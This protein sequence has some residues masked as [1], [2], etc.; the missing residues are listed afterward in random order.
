MNATLLHK[1]NPKRSKLTMPFRVIFPIGTLMVFLILTSCGTHKAG[2]TVNNSNTTQKSNVDKIRF[3]D[4]FFA[5]QTEKMKKENKKAISYFK[6]AL[7]IDNNNATCYYEIA[8]LYFSD[9]KLPDAEKHAQRAVY[10]E[11]HNKWFRLLLGD[12]YQYEKKWP[13][14][15]ENNEALISQYPDEKDYYTNLA[16]VYINQ[17]KANEAIKTYDRIEK[18]FGVENETLLQKYKIYYATQKYEKAAEQLN[19]IINR[20]PEN[21][22]YYLSLLAQCYIKSGNDTKALEL[23]SELEKNAPED[24]KIQMLIAEYYIGK[25]D[26]PKYMAAIKK[27]FASPALDIDS[28]VRI[29]YGSYLMANMDSTRLSDAA[30]LCEIIAQ[31]H[32]NDAKSHALYADILNEQNAY[33]QARIE[34]LKAI[35]LNNTKYLVWSQLL[36]IDAILKDYTNLEIDCKKALEIF[37]SQVEIY[38]FQ[39]VA[40]SALKKYQDCIDVVSSALNLLTGSEESKNIEL[41]LYMNRAEAYYRLQQ[42]KKS[43]DDFDKILLID[44]KNAIALNNYAYY[45]SVRNEKL[46]KAAEMSKRSLDLDPKSSTSM[47]TYGWILFRMGN[48]VEAEVYIKKALLGDNSAE[49][50]EHYADVLFKLQRVEEAVD[51]WKKSKKAGSE[52]PN[53]DKM[54]SEK[55]IIE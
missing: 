9:S 37:P 4:A 52:N 3:D 47:D 11:P 53:I 49:V 27:A 10:L 23:F 31:T 20:N 26:K 50:L 36:R 41:D 14:A 48:Y 15:I 17:N 42:F 25:G 21:K 54:I 40:Y 16:M 19:L 39:S 7:K 51:Y 38:Y 33:E 24:P 8:A 28:K 30:Q 55:R 6:D 46:E 5:A 35:A 18:H 1:F 12:I 29:I 34:Y 45:L 2:S 43:D 44:P 13:Q 32:P 22:N